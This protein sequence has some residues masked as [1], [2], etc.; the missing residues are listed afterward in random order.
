[1]ASFV[2]FDTNVYD[3]IY[4]KIN[5]SSGDLI[6]LK[7]AISSGK[8]SVLLSTL[9]VEETIAFMEYDQSMT[10]EQVQL[11]FSL[12]DK[13]RVIK[14]HNELFSE[15]IESFANR[16]LASGS[17]DRKYDLYS[18]MSFLQNPSQEDIDDFIST[19]NIHIKNQ[20]VD[21]SLFMKEVK[22]KIRPEIKKLKRSQANFI[23]FFE[24]VSVLFAESVAEKKGLLEQCRA[25]GIHNLLKVRSIRLYIG[26]SLSLAFAQFFEDCS[27]ESGDFIDQF[28]AT[29]SS[30]ADIFVTE[31]KKFKNRLSR[32]PIRNY[33]VIDLK[34]FTR[35]II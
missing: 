24:K 21:F 2:Y 15:D 11:I 29:V 32:I 5:F 34:E 26:Y 9:N 33:E 10:I 31:D 35:R 27:H 12:I 6:N 16:G 19:V 7:N 1:M 28:Q 20:K 23:D 3:H 30:A 13:Y 18:K 8:I 17:F 25:R 4:K 22:I 14:P